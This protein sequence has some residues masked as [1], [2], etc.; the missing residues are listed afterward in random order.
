M[1]ED[2]GSRLAKRLKSLRAEKSWSLEQLAQETGISRATLSRMENSEVS[3]TTDILSKLCAAYGLTLSRLLSM[4]EDSF[5]AKVSASDQPEWRDREKGFYRLSVS[6]PSQSLKAELLKCRI[7][8]GQVIAYD[9][10]SLPGLEHHL[11]LL[12]GSL[13]VTV[14]E[15]SYTLNAGDSL[16]YHSFGPTRFETPAGSAATYILAL[17]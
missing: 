2:L 4:V 1:Q 3:P 9:K 13:S 16:R 5:T 8:A 10:P 6:P 7:E 11:H 12:D 14:D 17:V 15:I